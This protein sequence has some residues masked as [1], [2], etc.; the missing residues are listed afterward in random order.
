VRGTALVL[1]LPIVPVLHQPIIQA[2]ADIDVERMGRT[3]RHRA[4]EAFVRQLLA[5]LSA[6]ADPPVRPSIFGL[7]Q[8][9]AEARWIPPSIVDAAAT[10]PDQAALDQAA[11][12]QVVRAVPERYGG[13][14]AGWPEAAV[15]LRAAGRYAVSLPLLEST[16]L[17]GWLLAGAGLELRPSSRTATRSGCRD[18]C[19]GYRTRASRS[20]SPS[21][22]AGPARV[23]ALLATAGRR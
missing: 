22:P 8:D 7:P 6:A 16:A 12:D 9:V 14:G 17:A 10:A 18:A 11:P 23:V 13:A 21:W 3:D 20:T 2:F 19:P 5:A 4:T 1:R 15:L